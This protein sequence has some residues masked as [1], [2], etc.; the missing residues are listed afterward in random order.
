M[1][2]YTPFGACICLH[3][4]HWGLYMFAYTTLALVYACRYTMEGCICLHVH[5]WSLHMHHWSM[6][7]LAYIP[8]GLV[9]ACICTIGACICFR[10]H[11]WGLYVL[12]YTQLGLVDARTYTKAN[13]ILSNPMGSPQMLSDPL[14]SIQNPVRA[15][16]GETHIY[17]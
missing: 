7:M 11:H 15:R 6:Y 14:K 2:A 12:A 17:I 16:G 8:L 10:T 3:I 4:H 5:H 13:Q 1:L 9:Y